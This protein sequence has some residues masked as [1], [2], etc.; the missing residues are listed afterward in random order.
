MRMWRRRTN[1]SV[2][3][4]KGREDAS[5]RKGSG[6]V[7]V[8]NSSKALKICSFVIQIHRLQ[9]KLLVRSS[10]EISV[11]SVE[12]TCR[13]KERRSG[14]FRSSAF[15][16]PTVERVRTRSN[17]AFFS[18]D[19]SPCGSRRRRVG[20]ASVAFFRP[21]AA[22]HATVGA[23]SLRRA[24]RR[25]ARARGRLQNLGHR[26][27]ARDR[28]SL[29]PRSAPPGSSLRRA[30]DGGV[31]AERGARPPGAGAAIPA[32]RSPRDAARPTRARRP[33]PRRDRR[34][35][36]SRRRARPAR[37]RRPRPGSAR[38][39]SA[40]PRAT[41]RSRP[42]AAEGAPRRGPRTRPIEPR[43]PRAARPGRDRSERQPRA[44]AK[45]R[46]RR[47]GPARRAHPPPP[48]PLPHPTTTTTTTRV[49]RR[50]S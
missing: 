38:A 8:R 26:D 22:R 18:R 10:T 41:R 1:R 7:M 15:F 49:P 40:R 19:P 36:R 23:S 34:S 29:P 43:P 5:E 9:A 37:G 39:G 14:E 33:T 31:D 11:R 16:S 48:P 2:D 20:F 47:A 30:R 35:P 24:R 42:R 45:S 21:R 46:V 12:S 32:R 25:L 6:H 13:T 4:L 28:A 27:S 44:R 3:H 50:S 17:A